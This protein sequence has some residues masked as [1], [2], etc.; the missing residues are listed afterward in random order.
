MVAG[1]NGLLDDPEYL[2]DAPLDTVAL[3]PEPKPK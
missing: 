1:S 2:R 3:L